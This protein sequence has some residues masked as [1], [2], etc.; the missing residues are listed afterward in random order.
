MGRVDWTGDGSIM[1]TVA[2]SIL[3]RIG[4]ALEMIPLGY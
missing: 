4:K 3:D 2:L 1:H